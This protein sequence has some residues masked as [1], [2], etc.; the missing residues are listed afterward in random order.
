MSTILIGSRPNSR[1]TIVPNAFVRDG[2]I[3]QRAFR[4]FVYLSSHSEGWRVDLAS[5]VEH[6]GMGRNTVYVA[7]KD[8][9]D[10]GY[11]TR[12]RQRG[13]GG[14]FA[15]ADYVLHPEPVPKNVTGPEQVK[16]PVSAGS[17][18][19]PKSVTWSDQEKDAVS[20][21]SHQVPNFGTH[22]KTKKKNKE[23]GVRVA[24]TCRSQ[25]DTTPSQDSFSTPPAAPSSPSDTPDVWSTA[26]DPRCRKHAALP[27]DRVPACRSCAQAREWFEERA[28]AAVAARR[29]LIDGC[30]WCDENGLAWTRRE[31]G[32]AVAV[33]CSHERAPVLVA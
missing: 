2:S 11:L 12:A 16:Q 1:F 26:E 23:E 14:Q 29:A 24:K 9:E 32:Q 17:H 3:P 18:Q 20:A 6:T 21:G 27:R 19:V 8:L 7:M 4:L 5:M 28:T 25:P 13:D 15:S 30:G 31:D 33:R 10:L 22:K